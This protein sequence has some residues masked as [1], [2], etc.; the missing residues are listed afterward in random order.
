MSRGLKGWYISMKGKQMICEEKLIKT[1]ENNKLFRE[2]VHKSTREV[3]CKDWIC[4][5]QVWENAC[6]KDEVCKTWRDYFIELIKDDVSI[7]TVGKEVRKERNRCMG[8]KDI[9]KEEVRRATRHHTKKLV[10]KDV[11]KVFFSIKVVDDWNKLWMQAA[12]KSLKSYLT[13][14]KVW[15]MGP[16]ECRTPPCAVQRGNHN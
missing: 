7:G 4:I 14:E 10:K 9:T 8:W 15:G 6:N 16:N 3:M 11:K 1:L 2:E 13:A 5:K 12:Y